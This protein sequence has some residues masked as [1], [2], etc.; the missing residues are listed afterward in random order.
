M[1][2]CSMERTELSNPVVREVTQHH[3]YDSVLVTLRKVVAEG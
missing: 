2:T 3:D 1:M